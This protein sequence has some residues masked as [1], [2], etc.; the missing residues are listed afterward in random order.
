[1]SW[2]RVQ[3]FRLWTA[4]ATIALIGLCFYYY[5]A[6]LQWYLRSATRSIE[7]AADFLPSP[8]AA[9]TEV[10]LR[11]IGASVWFQF[12]TAIVFFRVAMWAVGMLLWAMLFRRRPEPQL[13]LISRDETGPRERALP[14][15]ASRSDRMN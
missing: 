11:T 6:W 13:T 2:A 1:M 9:Q 5:P 3:F 7:V 10:V 15:G 4:L 14:G 8:W 12:A